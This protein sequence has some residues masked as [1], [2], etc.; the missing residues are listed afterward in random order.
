M[1]NAVDM[2][3]NWSGH[4][5]C[6]DGQAP[7]SADSLRELVADW[8][9]LLEQRNPD[10]QPVGLLA[11]NGANW[12]AIDLAA[13]SLHMPLV[14][15]PAFFT[16]EQLKHLCLQAGIRLLLTDEPTR[17]AALGYQVLGQFNGV[18]KAHAVAVPASATLLS[19][20]AK[21]TF[22]SGTTGAPKGVC[23]SQATQIDTAQ[24]LEV[25]TRGMGI[26]RHLSL[27]PFAV[28]LENIAGVYSPILANATLICPPVEEVGLLG[29]N[30]FYAERCWDQIAHYQAQSVVLLPQMLFALLSALKPNDPRGSSLKMVAVGGGKVPPSLLT[31]ADMLGLPVH[32]GYGLS[33]C[34]SVVCLNTPQ[35]RKAGTVGKPLRGLSVKVGQDGELLVHGRHYEGYLTEHGY[36]PALLQDGWLPTGDIGSMDAD[37]YVSIDGRK[38]NLIITSYGRN[39]SPEWPESLLL[40]TGLLQQVAVFGD[41]RSALCA[42]LVP[43][44][45]VS[46][47]QLD[48]CLPIVNKQLPA[49]AQV[50]DFIIADQAFQFSNGLATANGRIKRDAIWAKYADQFSSSLEVLS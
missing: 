48:G 32:E 5:Q 43:R 41:A 10:R 25:A 20:V 50:S 40:A 46:Q 21:V 1:V 24:A 47:S 27:L 49:Y 15:M 31:W 3:A 11:A 34:A 30:Q 28:L 36:Q 8:A 45:G 23:L 38:K 9:F 29:V 37:G 35:G 39:V 4:L 18:S 42:V 6:G 16:D 12:V 44:P 22:T 33:E 19:Q 14:P 7:M 26:E 2:L 17:A 13:A